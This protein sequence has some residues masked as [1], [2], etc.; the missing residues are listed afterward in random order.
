MLPNERSRDI[1]TA[2][3]DLLLFNI[4]K[5]MHPLGV[6][7]VSSLLYDRLRDSIMFVPLLLAPRIVAH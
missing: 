2:T 4:P 3:T 1:A 6:Q 5:F 7:V